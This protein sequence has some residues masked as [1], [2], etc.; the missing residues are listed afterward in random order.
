LVGGVRRLEFKPTPLIAINN[1]AGT[2]KLT[3]KSGPLSTIGGAGSVTLPLN[4]PNINIS[5]FNDS[6]SQASGQRIYGSGNTFNV[7]NT[8]T[9]SGAVGYGATGTLAT[10]PG[11]FDGYLYIGMGIQIATDSGFNSI[12]AEEVIASSNGQAIS[13]GSKAFSIAFSQTGTHYL[14]VFWTRI[15][16]SD[17]TAPTTFSSAVSTFTNSA[18]GQSVL[19]TELTDEGF[20]VINDTNIYFRVKREGTYLNTNT[21]FVQVGG[22]LS[23]TGNIIAYYSDRRL[24]N[25]EGKIDNP[26]EKLDKINGVYYRQNELAKEFGYNNNKRQVGLIAQEVEEVLPEVIQR[27]PFDINEEDGS[28]KTGENYLTI[29]Y[30]KIVPLLVEAVKEL[31]REIEELKKRK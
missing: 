11:G 14:R 5:A 7:P 31:K 6:T 20:Q 28:S 13:A 9:Y 4:S 25:I 27:A 21:P 12:V 15:L 23:A 30:D 1:A 16:F 2:P 10:T 29:D 22:I 26:L 3:I 24:K 18:L 19:I 17:T 8:G